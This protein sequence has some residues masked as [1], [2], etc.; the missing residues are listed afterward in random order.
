MGLEFELPE[1]A[2][3]I[4]PDEAGGLIPSIAT[5]SE[6]NTF[7]AINIVEAANWAIG[8]KR[9]LRT[10]LSDDGLRRLHKRMFNRTWKWAGVYRLTQTSIGV[11]AYRISMEVRNLIADVKCWLEFSSYPPAEIA[12]RFHHRLVEIHPFVN[13][14]GRHARLAT[15]LLC[16]F[17]CWPISKWGAANLVQDGEIRR[18]YIQALK[19]ADRRDYVPLIEFMDLRFPEKSS[20]TVVLSK[21]DTQIRLKY[22]A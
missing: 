1:G 7:E 4:T 15:D 5:Q 6:L 3:P 19:S 21:A 16:E 14:N 13:G 10:L 18:R 22:E 11:E 17:Q 2:T 8:N 9:F 12:A 20:E